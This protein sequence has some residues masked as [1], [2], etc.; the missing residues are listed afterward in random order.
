MGKNALAI[1]KTS[2]PPT[3]KIQLRKNLKHSITCMNKTTLK[4]LYFS[5]G[6]IKLAGDSCHHDHFLSDSMAYTV[7][8]QK[9]QKLLL[10]L[11]RKHLT[12]FK[13]SKITFPANHKNAG[14]NSVYKTINNM[15]KFMH[16]KMYFKNR[17]E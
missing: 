14:M 12:Y 2:S 5:A 9:K 6:N 4:F 8:A 1:R 15:H 3:G 17:R 7:S 11:E 16:P 10:A 13:R